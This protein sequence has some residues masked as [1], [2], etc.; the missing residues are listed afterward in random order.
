MRLRKKLDEIIERRK[1]KGPLLKFIKERPL[2]Q[3]LF[4]DFK[5]E[6]LDADEFDTKLKKDLINT[7]RGEEVL[8]LSPFTHKEKLDDLL[9]ILKGAIKNGA[10][11]VVQTLDPSYFATINQK[12]KEDWQRKN[13]QR[14]EDAG[15]DVIT[16]K[17]MH[18]KAVI[19]G[20]RVAYLGSTNVLSKLEGKGDYMLRYSNPELVRVFYYFLFEL[21][22]ASEMG[23]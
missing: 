6:P 9:P 21:A 16:R 1:D 15:I 8:I 14:L 11:V 7:E 17:N 23:E 4:E 5:P 13:I 19:I 2:L 10:K 12:S 22:Q 3:K 18:E 20:E